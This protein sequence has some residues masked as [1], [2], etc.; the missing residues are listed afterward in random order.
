[1]RLKKWLP[2]FLSLVLACASA[3]EPVLTLSVDS[4]WMGTKKHI[5]LRD[6]TYAV[7]IVNVTK[8]GKVTTSS[9]EG[10]LSKETYR[11]LLRL[12]D[13]LN[14]SEL[15]AGYVDKNIQITNVNATTVGLAY[16]GQKKSVFILGITYP[17]ELAAILD[18]VTPLMHT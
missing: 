9:S 8:D 11:E 15:K 2:C 17:K 16:K 14:I 13:G 12:M 7:T 3:R 1:M 5:E 18:I 6:R 4:S 10:R